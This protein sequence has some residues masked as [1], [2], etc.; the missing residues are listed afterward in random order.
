MSEKLKISYEELND[1]RIDESLKRKKSEEALRTGTATA[2]QELARTSLIHQNWFNL[3]LAG[4][5]G[6]F[7]AW[8]L[9][10]PHIHEDYNNYTESMLTLLIMSMGACIGL[11][12]GS[13]E[14]LLARNFKRAAKAGLAGLGIGFAGAI[15]ASVIIGLVYPVLDNLGQA[16][17]SPEAIEDPSRYFSGFIFIMIRRSILWAILGMTVGL[18]PGIGLNSKKLIYNGFIGGMIGGAIG[19]LLFDPINYLVSGGTLD[20]GA[21]VS[22]GIGFSALG[23]MTGLMIGLVEAMSKDAWLLMSVGFLK[24][25]QFIVYKNPTVIGSSPKCEIYLF[26]DPDI[27][28]LHAKISK[29]RDGFEIE[30]L[31]PDGSGTW[32]NGKRT[33]RRRLNNGDQIQIGKSTFI[34]SEKVNKE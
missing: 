12:I 18:G 22:R 21:S 33:G 23:A 31:N 3:M 28:P 4:F 5:L 15:A 29:L 14:G 32:I 30:D 24:G 16:F 1:P 13:M 20:H 19:G 8:A 7:L 11:T 6:A 10:E 2:S 26:K 17:I 27:E 34:F 25:K 9:I